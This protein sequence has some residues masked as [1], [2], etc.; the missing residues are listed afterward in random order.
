MYL[1]RNFYKT[2]KNANSSLTVFSHCLLLPT[3]LSGELPQADWSLLPCSVNRLSLSSLGP[4]FPHPLPVLQEISP[5]VLC[6]DR[7]RDHLSGTNTNGNELL[8][9]MSH[10]LRINR[11]KITENKPC[12]IYE[13]RKE[14]F[15]MMRK[16]DGIMTLCL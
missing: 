7:Q 5:S 9:I 2:T 16:N 12:I 1:A 13:N 15:P 3:I 8:H 10:L 6:V 14:I 4:F 11:F